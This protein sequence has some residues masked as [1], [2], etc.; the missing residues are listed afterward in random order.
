[1]CGENQSRRLCAQLIKKSRLGIST[2]F[3][4]STAKKDFRPQEGI[5]DQKGRK[6]IPEVEKFQL[7]GNM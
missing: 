3:S 1:M 4:I 6:S 7:M 5:S 2:I